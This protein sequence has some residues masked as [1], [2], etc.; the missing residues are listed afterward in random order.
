[1][2]T[3]ALMI[4]LHVFKITQAYLRRKEIAR[5]EPLAR[6]ICGRNRK[7]L[8]SGEPFFALQFLQI[9]NLTLPRRMPSPRNLSS[10]TSFVSSAP[11]QDKAGYTHCFLV[12]SRW[13][14]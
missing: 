11:T 14:E 3:A 8:P 12:Q 6:N 10:C 13:H 4:P 1:M 5:G 7:A 2:W 9:D